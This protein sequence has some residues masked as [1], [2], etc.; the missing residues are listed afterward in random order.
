MFMFLQVLEKRNKI[1]RENALCIVIPP[2][3]AMCF[4][5]TVRSKLHGKPDRHTTYTELKC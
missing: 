2:S 1:T 5:K 4:L 3:K